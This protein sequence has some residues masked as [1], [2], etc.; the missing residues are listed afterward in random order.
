MCQKTYDILSL[1]PAMRLNDE[2]MGSKEKMWLEIDGENWLF[3]FPRPNT[4]EHWAEKAA[5]ELADLI[6]LD[7]ATVELATLKGEPGTVSRSFVPS[8]ATLTHGNE[9]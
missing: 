1:T 8:G 6:D 9:L 3:K 5:A 7:A 4:G 2:P